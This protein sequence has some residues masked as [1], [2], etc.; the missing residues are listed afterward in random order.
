VTVTLPKSIPFTSTLLVLRFWRD[1][2]ASLTHRQQAGHSPLCGD[3]KA[4]AYLLLHLQD[5]VPD[6]HRCTL[7]WDDL[8]DVA[9]RGGERPVEAETLD[10]REV[11]ICSKEPAPV[12]G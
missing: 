2:N 8:K 9:G 11:V 12:L 10:R 5:D 6:I 7:E 3:H 1:R 4:S